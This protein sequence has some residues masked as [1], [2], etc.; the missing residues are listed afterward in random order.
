MQDGFCFVSFEAQSRDKV[1]KL[2]FNGA[3]KNCLAYYTVLGY[4]VLFVEH[5]EMGWFSRI[6]T[7]KDSLNETLFSFS[8]FNWRGR[9]VMA[10]EKDLELAKKRWEIQTLLALGKTVGLQNFVSQRRNKH[11]QS[12][13]VF[14][15][16]SRLFES[17]FVLLQTGLKRT[18]L[19]TLLL[20]HLDL[21]AQFF[22]FGSEM[23]VLILEQKDQSYKL[24]QVNFF[25]LR[26]AVTRKF[27]HFSFNVF[28]HFFCLFYIDRGLGG[29]QSVCK[30]CVIFF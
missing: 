20:R 10:F 30:S 25:Q 13:A 27:R 23:V 24:I 17:C 4:P 15:G 2:A 19:E 14:E 6:S 22:E 5:L 8:I 3:C 1:F 9:V 29:F 18:Y 28:H 7:S 11:D 12:E 16:L 21:Y 26:D